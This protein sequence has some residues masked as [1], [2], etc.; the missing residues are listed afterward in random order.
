VADGAADALKAAED[1]VGKMQAHRQGFEGL[2]ADDMA[3]AAV[4]E[5]TLKDRVGRCS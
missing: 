4:A 5:Q 3:D 2:M 1:F